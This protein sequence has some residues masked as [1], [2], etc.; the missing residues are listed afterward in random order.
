[1]IEK[2]LNGICTLLDEECKVPKG[3]DEGFL[4]RLDAAHSR[5]PFFGTTYLLTFT[6]LPELSLDPS[7]QAYP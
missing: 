3:T 7:P 6:L 1:M 5:N 2:G 4:N